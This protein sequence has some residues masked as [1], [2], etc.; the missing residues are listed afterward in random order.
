M[1][2]KISEIDLRKYYIEENHSKE[3]TRKH[4]NLTNWSLSKLF[5]FYGIRKPPTIVSEIRAKTKRIR[6]GSE[7]YNNRQ[8]FRETEKERY[9]GVG[10]ASEFCRIKANSTTLSRYGNADI[11]KTKHFKDKS[12]QTKLEKYGKGTYN[13]PKKSKETL[14]KRYGF[15]NPIFTHIKSSEPERRV[16]EA[17]G[18]HSY[19]L[20]NREFDVKVG[21]TLIEVDGEFWHPYSIKNLKLTQLRN[22][23]NDYTKEQIARERGFELLR[24]HVK[25]IPEEITVDSLRKVNY[26]PTYKIGYSEDILSKS[27]LEKFISTYGKDVLEKN[28]LSDMVPTIR[29]CSPEFPDIPQ[30]E[31][32]FTV[33]GCLRKT[34]FTFYK[35]HGHFSFN[36]SNLGSNVIKSRFRSFW[37][38][39]NRGRL[40]P[41]QAWQSDE[42]LENIIRYRIGLNDTGEC[43]GLSLKQIVRGL[44]INHFLV[45]FF[46]PSLAASIYKHYL[47]DVISPVVFDPSAGFGARLLAFKSLYPDGT[48]IACEPNPETFKEL[49]DL[50]EEANFSNVIL[51]SCKLEDLQEVPSYDFGFTS[52]PY[53]DLETYSVPVSYGSF[54]EWKGLFW[55]KL[56]SLPNM[57]AVVN[58]QL[59]DLLKGEDSSLKVVDF[60]SK[61]RNPLGSNQ[62]TREYIVKKV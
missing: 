38:A 32:L 28:F 20:E 6:Y 5:T 12:T 45:S 46:K 33:I 19:R 55:N 49:Q 2:E 56:I 43:F 18:G 17:L 52:P 47:G 13:N 51:H 16:R 21:N 62:N 60:I 29:L 15:D 27:T 8:K 40:S 30:E 31:D 42:I 41:V 54:E 7:T 3:E 59:L 35:K 26:R 4:F 58:G 1:K 25:N 48:Y 10:Y 14:K 61:N 39:S 23:V 37:K 34:D 11:R 9:G 36:C 57:H 24:V 50:V 22:I 44:N 53:Y